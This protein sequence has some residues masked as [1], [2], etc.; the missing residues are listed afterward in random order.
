MVKAGEAAVCRGI[1]ERAPCRFSRSQR[2][3]TEKVKS[4]M[5]YPVSSF[6]RI[7]DPRHFLIVRVRAHLW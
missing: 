3:A 5:T 4:A 7:R 2:P 1:L 6:A